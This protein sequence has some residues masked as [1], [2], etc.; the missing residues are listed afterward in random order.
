MFLNTLFWNLYY[1]CVARLSLTNAVSSLSA[2]LKTPSLSPVYYQCGLFWRVER[3]RKAPG[4][5]QATCTQNVF[6][7][8]TKIMITTLSLCRKHVS[9]KCRYVRTCHAA[10]CTPAP[11]RHCVLKWKAAEVETSW[12]RVTDACCSLFL[13]YSLIRNALVLVACALGLARYS[14]AYQ[15]WPIKC[16]LAFYFLPSASSCGRVSSCVI[17]WKRF[18]RKRLWPSR[19]LGVCPDRLTLTGVVP[20][21]E[22][23][24]SPPSTTNEDGE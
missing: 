6:R 16:V 22:P 10:A 11:N 7:H 14:Q 5:Q 13:V 18:E 23:V 21:F 2:F 20:R 1:G 9:P 12:Y 8:R 3:N 24:V 17:N 15:V 4:F 19:D